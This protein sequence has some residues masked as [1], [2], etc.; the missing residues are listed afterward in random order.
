MPQ[1]DVVVIGA[2]IGGVSALRLL[3]SQFPAD[4]PG[5]VCVVLH[6][7][8]HESAL[9]ELLS[10]A[11]P[12]PAVHAA[13][14]MPALPGRIHVAPPGH[15]LLL[16]GDRLMLSRGPKEHH[17]RPA[18]DPLFRSAALSAGPRVIG[19]VLTGRLDDG[20]AGLQA[21]KACGGLAVVQDPADAE[22]PGM[23][24][25][26]L[27]AV[28]ADHCVPLAAVAPLLAELV[29]QPA[30]PP[31]SAP[32]P[33][34]VHEQLAS[35]GSGNAMD[36]LPYFARPSTLACPDC[37]GTLWEVTGSQP[38]R[39]R[40]HTGH[41]FSLR[42]LAAAQAAATE[43]ALWSGVRALQEKELLL[44]RIAALDR[45]AGD[46]TH[47]RDTELQADR[48]HRQA[49]LLRSLTEAQAAGDDGE[50]RDD[51]TAL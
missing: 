17:T 13:N 30:P 22:E 28:A 49:A 2:S 41:A 42:S 14:G 27:A 35:S 5:I 12:L 43:E 1:R 3:A 38:P 31:P 20:S 26:A 6:I 39:F 46:E 36:E 51:A 34:L 9:P 40:C 33:W 48:L 44:R 23:P 7:G 19:V 4:F 15:H 8:T 10:A 47:A 45:S 24:R 11:G 50:E 37:R 25:S 18:I 29:R 32:P 16:D 21:I